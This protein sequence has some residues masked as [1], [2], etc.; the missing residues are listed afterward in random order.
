MNTVM[1][2]ATETSRNR[3]RTKATAR[4]R[5]MNTGMTMNT[6]MKYIEPEES[7]IIKVKL[8]NDKEVIL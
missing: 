4:S 2:I 1:N 3:D 5:G 6:D 7:H 8:L